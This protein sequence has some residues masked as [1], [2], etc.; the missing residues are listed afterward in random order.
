MFFLQFH[1]CSQ[2]AQL[3]RWLVVRL[4]TDDLDA[5]KSTGNRIARYKCYERSLIDAKIEMKRQLLLVLVPG[6][7]PPL[8][9][10]TAVV[11]VHSDLLRQ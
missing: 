4:K 8:R 6:Y 7:D 3:G 5:K 1:P 2:I 9:R 11:I 10:A